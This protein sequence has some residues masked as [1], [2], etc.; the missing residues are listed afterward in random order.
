MWDAATLWG[1]GGGEDAVGGVLVSH[2]D[3]NR[4]LIGYL[5]ELPS[6]MSRVRRELRALRFNRFI[7]EQEL[8]IAGQHSWALLEH[9]WV[10]DRDEVNNLAN[11]LD[12]EEEGAPPPQQPPAEQGL[13][14][15]LV[16]SISP[17]MAKKAA[18]EGKGGW[19]AVSGPARMMSACAGVAPLIL[20]IINRLSIQHPPNADRGPDASERH[21]SADEALLER[22]AGHEPDASSGA[23]AAGGVD[24]VVEQGGFSTVAGL[25]AAFGQ[26][27][28][29]MGGL[30][31]EKLAAGLSESKGVLSS[32]LVM[33]AR[34]RMYR[35]WIAFACLVGLDAY[36]DRGN[37]R[38]TAFFLWVFGVPF[39]IVQAATTIASN[40]LDPEGAAL[41]WGV[42]GMVTI[43]IGSICAVVMHRVVQVQRDAVQSRRVVSLTRDNISNRIAMLCIL[44]ETW[45]LCSLAFG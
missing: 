25:R 20:E 1:E 37:A 42:G 29:H 36:G 3:G 45:Q 14:R 9:E 33:Y 31:S 23:A 10:S 18:W 5:D 26:C 35:A 39:I 4:E 32:G 24:I 16:M 15:A 21:Q 17:K 12:E 38:L 43:Y 6:R 40:T 30:T 19:E 13:A 8:E 11:R 2:A 41:R 28:Q 27:V 22:V 7:H 34:N 44:I